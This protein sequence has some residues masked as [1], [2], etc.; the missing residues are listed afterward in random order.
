M[1]SATPRAVRKKLLLLEGALHRLELQQAT[2][3]LHSA[4]FG[5]TAGKLGRRLPALLSFL[6]RHQ[7]GT[8]L[9]SA[10]P[11]LLGGSRLS[12]IARRATLLVGTGAAL[13]GMLERWRRSRLAR[14]LDDAA[15]SAAADGG[16]AAK[17]GQGRE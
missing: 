12:R 13:F 6:S 15:A 11:W 3:S 8:L 1:K 5:G 17:P 2:A 9:M 7:A 16:T 14:E 10:L 4:A